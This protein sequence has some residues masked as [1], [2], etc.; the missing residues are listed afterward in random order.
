MT[1]NDILRR[2]RYTFDLDDNSVMELFTSGGVPADRTQISDW[3]KKEEDE[4]YKNLSDKYLSA[5]LNGFINKKRGKRDGDQPL[6]EKNLNNNIIFRKIR[7]ALTMTD[8]DI[9]DVLDLADFRVSKSELSAFF[10]K[11]DHRHFRECKDQIIRNFLHGLQ[12][13]YKDND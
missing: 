1:N 7:I 2:L 4:A 11:P 13:K 9:I 10:R 8:E 5:F 3:M 12:L 6:P